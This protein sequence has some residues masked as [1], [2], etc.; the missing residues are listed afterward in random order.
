MR[1][2][3]TFA[4]GVMVLA[5]LSQTSSVQAQLPECT[6]TFDTT[7][8]NAG[9]ECGATFSGGTGCIFAGLG[10]CY[11]TGLKSYGV[12]SVSPLTISL[13]DDLNSLEVFIAHQGAGVSGTMRF[14][15]AEV[16]GNEVDAPLMTNGN[17]LLVM[18]ARQLVFFSVPVVSKNSN[19]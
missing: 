8:P 19:A 15:D 18:P 3:T 7:C 9:A 4:G 10:L 5:I 11:D 13:S 1:F 16:G 17:C 12:S 14:F 6:I 2:T